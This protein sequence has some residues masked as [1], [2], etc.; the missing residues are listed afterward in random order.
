MAGPDFLPIKVVVPSE[1]DFKEPNER[2]G[3]F[4]PLCDVDTEY[5]ERFA[6]QVQGVF[7]VFQTSL[8]D[9]VP[10]VAKIVL[11]EEARKKSYRPSQ[12][13]NKDTCPII[14]VSDAGTL[15]VSV[16]SQGLQRL[17]RQI[18]T[19]NTQLATAH[20]ST[21]NEISAYG[22]ADA[23]VDSASDGKQS[24][25][26]KHSIRVKLFRHLNRNLDDRLERAFQEYAERNGISDIKKVNYG[27]GVCMYRCASPEPSA[28]A[29]L[30]SFVGAQSVSDM[31][32]FKLVRTASRVV[33]PM[34]LENFPLPIDGVDYPIVGIFDSG[35]DPNNEALQQ[36]VVDRH[37]WPPQSDQDNSHGSFVAG[38]IANGRQLNHGN[39]RFPAA[40]CKIVDV[41][42]FDQSGTA[43]EADLLEFFEQA[44]ND[45]PDVRVWNLSLALAG[46]PCR[47]DMVSEF[48]AAID[49]LQRRFN[50]LFV[51]A[52]GNMIQAPFRAW[53]VDPEFIGQDRIAPPSDSLRALTVGGIAHTENDRSC[54]KRE[55]VSPFSLKG[56]ALGGLVKPE[57]SHYAGNCDSSGNCMQTGVVSLGIGGQVAEDIGVSYATPL[58]TAIAGSV[59]HELDVDGSSAPSPALVKAL[60]VHSSFVKN[61]PTK[62]ELVEY[63]GLGRPGDIDE[64]LNCKQSSATVIF[65]VPV[66]RR[67]RFYKHPFAVPPCLAV[68]GKLKCEV[69][70]TLIYD[71]PLDRA[72]GIEYCRRNIDASLGFLDIDEEKGEVYRGREVDPSPKDLHKRYPAE[73]SDFGLQWSPVKFYHRK[74]SK[75]EAGRDWRL[76]LKLLNRAECLDEDPIDTHLIVTVKSNSPDAQVYTE[77]VRE[78][79]NLGWTV[80]NLQIRSR[81]RE[82]F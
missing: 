26:E 72:Y 2:G 38:L 3:G 45:F 24:A 78:M 16:T 23:L 67:P 15:F 14:G 80:S 43:E 63:T 11:K 49:D 55:Q 74:F 41:V 66:G 76:S 9:D 22:K 39:P 27:D 75:T 19:G 56:P 54:V 51:N 65:Q 37:D 44:L 48:G 42:V 10:G 61:G 31:P 58:V 6:S 77:M 52:T 40:S 81:F 20:L 50:V 71:P 60:V 18:R 8:D 62:P 64:I 4:E 73:W 30:A 25:S 53:P 82:Q 17:E 7:E 5:R 36:W 47:S 13:L 12:I 1:R 33:G 21:L 70:M 59:A 46:V 35:T 32:Q 69:F 79:D 29:T 34:T 28:K 68:K 57:V